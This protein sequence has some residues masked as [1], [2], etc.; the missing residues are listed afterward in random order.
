MMAMFSFMYTAAFSIYIILSSFISI[1]TTLGINAIVDAKYK[2][3]QENQPKQ[4]VRGRV[5]VKK[6]VPQEKPKSKKE[7]KVIEKLNA[8][9]FL[10]ASAEKKKR[11]K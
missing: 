8:P 11:K 2:N 5:Y 4:V 6:E 10:N 9:D 3:K 1:L 7:R